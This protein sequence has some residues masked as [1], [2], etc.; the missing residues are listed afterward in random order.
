MAT[1]PGK[2]SSIITMRHRIRNDEIRRVGVT[3]ALDYIT[4]QQ[5]KWFKHVTCM[6]PDNIKRLRG[7]PP[8]QRYNRILENDS[9]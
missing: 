2:E 3:S 7:R 4:K 5:I 8:K 9:L 6:S 1:V